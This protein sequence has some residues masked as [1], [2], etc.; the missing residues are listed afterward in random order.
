MYVSLLGLT[1]LVSC[2]DNVLLVVLFNSIL[3]K[4]L[5]C[6]SNLAYALLGHCIVHHY[7]PL[8]TFAKYVENNILKPLEMTSTGFDYTKR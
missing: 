5:Y 3:Q 8:T 1:I 7:D 4:L 2:H 6:C